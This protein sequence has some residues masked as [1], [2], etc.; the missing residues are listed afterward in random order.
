MKMDVFNKAFEISVGHEGGYVN[1]PKDRGGET[2]YG[3]TKKTYPHLD[4]KN[5]S[6]E[7][8]KKIYYNDFWNTKQA[9]LNL[10]SE[11]IAI[12]VFDTGI[13]TSMRTAIEIFQTALNLLNRVESRYDDVVVDGF[14]GSDTLKVL[15]KVDEL[16]LLRVLNGLQ[17]CR[18]YEI[19]KNN[20]SQ[21]RF[22]AGWIKRT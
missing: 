8:A 1:D 10:L 5:L 17:F 9:D 12:E 2:K 18:Y 19:V 20:H 11:K 15:D 4:I 14:M 21:E 7:E 6:L 13:N 3:V 22:F 16:E